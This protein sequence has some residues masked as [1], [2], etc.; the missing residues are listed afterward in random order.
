MASSD[1]ATRLISKKKKILMI[2]NKLSDNRLT[3]ILQ[4]AFIVMQSQ[5]NSC[6]THSTL[7]NATPNIKII[8]KIVLIMLRYLR[9]FGLYLDIPPYLPFY[10]YETL[11][12]A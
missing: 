3:E 6:H 5:I 12:I 1:I 4:F 2:I 7:P 10:L 8:A 11:K 9:V